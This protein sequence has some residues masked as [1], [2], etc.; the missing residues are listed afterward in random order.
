MSLIRFVLFAILAIAAGCSKPATETTTVRLAYGRKMQYAPQIVAAETG[1]FQ[2]QGVTVESQLMVGGIQCAEAVTTG[3]ADMAAMGDVPA[4]IAAAS[5]APVKI[6]LRYAGNENMHRIVAAPDSGITTAADLV[7]KR[8]AVQKGSST[9]GAFLLFCQAKG[10]DVR[11]LKLVDLNPRYMP[12]AVAAKEVDAIVG[13]EPWPSNVEATVPGSHSVCCLSGLGNEFPH[14]VLVSARF[15]ETHPDAVRAV[16]RAL[17]EAVARINADPATAAAVLSKVTGVPADREERDLR[18][19]DWRIT[20]D[21][22]VRA[23]L[24][25]TAEFLHESGQI[26]ALPDLDQC[27]DASFLPAG[28]QP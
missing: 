25:Q 17:N 23:S 12:E 7:G 10:L 6:V 8:I 13:S 19:F 14:L 9:Y 18:A 27:L 20:L 22:K 26:P 5:G 1:L 11:S 16:V 4:L 28:D 24:R 3:A 2:A 15:A 21:D